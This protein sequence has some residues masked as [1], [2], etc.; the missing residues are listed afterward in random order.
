[1]VL[2]L[3]SAKRSV[4]TLLGYILLVVTAESA[5]LLVVIFLS[6]IIGRRAVPVK[7]PFNLMRPFTVSVASGV[8]LFMA[9]FTK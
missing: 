3:E 2:T 7:S 9:S 8:A 5:N 6:P 1:M 4:V